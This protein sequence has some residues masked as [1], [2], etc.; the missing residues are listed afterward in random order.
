MADLDPELD[1]ELGQDELLRGLPPEDRAAVERWSERAALDS[2]EG[3]KDKDAE[4]S[5]RDSKRLPR[6]Q[7][8]TMKNDGDH[9]DSDAM[10]ELREMTRESLDAEARELEEW[11]YDHYAL[12]LAAGQVDSGRMQRWRQYR[13]KLI[14]AV[15]DDERFER[16]VAPIDTKWRPILEDIPRRLKEPRAC[17]ECG[18]PTVFEVLY[19]DV[20]GECYSPPSAVR[21]EDDR[22]TIPF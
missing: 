16:V 8:A 15:I 18:T 19:V 12:Y 14:R 3:T 11:E 9:E 22:D 1:P 13:L 5:A 17:R 7:E 4:H 20:C 21:Q 2:K 10:R 6:C